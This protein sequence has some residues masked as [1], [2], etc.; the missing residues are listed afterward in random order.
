MILRT[1]LCAL[2]AALSLPSA[3]FAQSAPEATTAAADTTW[4]SNPGTDAQ[5]HSRNCSVFPLR[6]GLFPLFFMDSIGTLVSVEGTASTPMG[7]KLQVDAHPALDG[8]FP[9]PSED[10]VNALMAQIRANGATLR[11]SRMVLANGK[12]DTAVEEIPLAGAVEQFDKC[13]EW[14]AG[15]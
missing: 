6:G 2:V 5:T 4:T 12:L 11:V 10:V 9:S 15:K 1:S 7:V 3:A 13:R 8:G 14:L